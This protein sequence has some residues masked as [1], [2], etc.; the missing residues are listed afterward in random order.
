MQTS[1]EKQASIKMQAKGSIIME[2]VLTKRTNYWIISDWKR[3]EKDLKAL[4]AWLKNIEVRIRQAQPD[5]KMRWSEIKGE[6]IF[7]YL[8]HLQNKANRHRNRI[9]EINTTIGNI[10]D[11]WD[12]MSNEYGQ[13]RLQNAAKD[14][15][16]QYLIYNN[17]KRKTA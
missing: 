14:G 8:L 11:Y 7:H 9:M 10:I 5:Y 1:S 6:L 17:Q 16:Q 2:Y 3:I 4:Q 13:G 12:W 15:Y